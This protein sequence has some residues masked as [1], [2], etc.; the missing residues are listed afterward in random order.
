MALR[1]YTLSGSPFGWKVQ[2]ALEHK[3]IPYVVTW[4]SADRGD[5]D[6]EWY[7]ALNPHGKAPVLVDGDFVLSESDAIVEYLEEAFP[8]RGSSLWPRDARR[9][10]L[11]RRIA[12]ETSAY[13]YPPI[14][15][16]VT[17]WSSPEAA[18]GVVDEAKTKIEASVARFACLLSAPFF[19][20]AETGAADFAVYPL[21]ALI[22]RLDARQPEEGLAAL[23]PDT[24]YRWSREVEN[25]LGFTATYPPHWRATP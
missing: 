20:G 16:L 18:R 6:A 12:L 23:I 2:L 3:R 9:R 19:S 22:K 17:N 15:A 10:A 1:L 11:A 24:I 13:L 21:V 5:L 4:V 7:R 14:R 8:T 25:M